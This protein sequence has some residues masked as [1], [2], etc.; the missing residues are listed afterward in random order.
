MKK[1]FNIELAMTKED[2]EYFE[3][4]IECWI[5]SYGYVDSFIARDYCCATRKHDTCMDRWFWVT[6]A[7]A[8]LFCL[9]IVKCLPFITVY[10]SKANTT[11]S[12]F[13]KF[14]N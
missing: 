8:L 3:N 6:D 2:N 11:T 5:C 7:S 10:H 14:Q 4:F 9:T 12:T 13:L 1:D